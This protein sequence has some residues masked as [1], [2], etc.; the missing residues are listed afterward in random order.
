MFPNVS[1]ELDFL[2]NPISAACTFQSEA[3][4]AGDK[5]QQRSVGE[6]VFSRLRL[7][8]PAGKA[9][10]HPTACTWITWRTNCEYVKEE[11][12]LKF[13]KGVNLVILTLYNNK[14]N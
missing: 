4:Q 6:L 2:I 13:I 9:T 5:R 7:N 14:N 8:N 3:N 12:N 1:I 11:T 10:R